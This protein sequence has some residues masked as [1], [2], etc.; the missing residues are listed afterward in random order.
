MPSH[1]IATSATAA[2]IITGKSMR[3]VRSSRDRGQSRALSPRMKRMLNVLVPAM[4]PTASDPAPISA[5]SIPTASSG[6]LVPTDTTVRP[7]SIGGMP[8]KAASR[9]PARTRISA[10]TISAKSP[11]MH[12]AAAVIMFQAEFC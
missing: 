9:V 10:P 1:A 12:H 6:R 5:A 4:L 2:A 11:N 3:T 7:I 8:I